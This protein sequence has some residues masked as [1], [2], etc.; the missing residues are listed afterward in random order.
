MTVQGGPLEGQ[1]LAGGKQ[2]W[3]FFMRQCPGGSSTL[4]RGMVRWQ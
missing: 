3:V 2:I 4:N 1:I